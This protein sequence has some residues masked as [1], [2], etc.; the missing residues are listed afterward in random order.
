MRKTN[1][2]PTKNLM[3]LNNIEINTKEPIEKRIKHFINQIGDPHFF[4]IGDITIE[5]ESVSNRSLFDAFMS[6]YTKE[7]SCDS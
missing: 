1:E 3:D 2:P 4:K 6:V 5:V 7:D